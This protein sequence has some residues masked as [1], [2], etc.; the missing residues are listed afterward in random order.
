[1]KQKAHIELFSGCLRVFEPGKSYGD[2]YIFSCSVHWINCDEVELKGVTSYSPKYR[3][4]LCDALAR[5]GVK[6]LRW[7]R[8]GANSDRV[9][10][11]DTS[12][13]KICIDK[14]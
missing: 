7:T 10:R 3:R 12:T 1:M 9:V 5:Y 13:Y 4:P 6:V 8:K 2:E 14:K 11:V